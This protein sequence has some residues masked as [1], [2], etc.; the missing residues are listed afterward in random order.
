MVGTP[1]MAVARSACT[2]RM[3]SSASK[4][5]IRVSFMPATI[6]TFRSAKQP[7]TWKK[8]MQTTKPFWAADGSGAGG[9]S[10]R[11]TKAR[12]WEKRPLKTAALAA[13]WLAGTPLAFPVV[14]DV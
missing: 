6:A 12:A 7:V 11:R 5:R 9:A 10:P 1:P 4:R 3:A 14:P 13:R 2:S 8:G